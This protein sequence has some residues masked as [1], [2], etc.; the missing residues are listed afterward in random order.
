MYTDYFLD[1]ENLS[2]DVVH[3]IS[4]LDKSDKFYIFYSDTSQKP[5]YEILY[6]IINA[7]CKVEFIECKNGT[8]NSMDFKI[9]TFIGLKVGS[10]KNMKHNKHHYVIL[11]NDKGYDT[12][13]EYYRSMNISMERW[14]NLL[15]VLKEDV[16]KQKQEEEKIQKEKKKEDVTFAKGTSIRC[17]YSHALYSPLHHF[18]KAP[19][20]HQECKAAQLVRM[21]KAPAYDFIADEDVLDEIRLHPACSVSPFLFNYIRRSNAGL[22]QNFDIMYRRDAPETSHLCIV[23]KFPWEFPFKAAIPR[24]EYFEMGET[25]GGLFP[26]VHSIDRQ[27]F[28]LAQAEDDFDLTPF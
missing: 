28:L 21:V 16:L 27:L 20:E 8:P 7:K 18:D 14:G 19:Q 23:Y 2:G 25:I 22:M 13:V 1:S 4:E 3:E 9:V 15:P 6:K 10:Y 5:T 17:Y 26:S 11:S 24:T 12:T